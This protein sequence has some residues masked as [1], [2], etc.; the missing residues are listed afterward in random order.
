M[1]FCHD[2]GGDGDVLLAGICGCLE[3][4]VRASSG[5]ARNRLEIADA[6]T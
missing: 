3:I 1:V 6:S 5:F 4:P 2:G